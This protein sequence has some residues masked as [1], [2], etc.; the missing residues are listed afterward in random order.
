M[1]IFLLGPGRYLSPKLQYGGLLVH[2]VSGAGS[3]IS[4]L[5]KVDAHKSLDEVGI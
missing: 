4:S 1:D 2:G 3:K 5:S